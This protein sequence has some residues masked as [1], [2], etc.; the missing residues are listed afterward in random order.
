MITQGI[1]RRYASALADVAVKQN[2]A[3]Q[4]KQELAT[5]EAMMTASPELAEVLR[6]PV[7]PQ[8]QKKNLL[9]AL[10]ARTNVNQITAN[11]FNVLLQN[12]RLADLPEVSQAFAGEMDKRL[13]IVSAHVTTAR[14]LDSEARETLHKQI[15]QMLNKQVRLEFATDENLIGGVVTRIGSTV[16]D[17]SV[18]NQLEEIK[19]KLKGERF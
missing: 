7:V 11:F 12:N 3:P 15:S 18:R 5:W 2:I 16:F 19:D 1:A 10:I 14:E 9:T 13:G 17:G 4:V 8:E 6:N